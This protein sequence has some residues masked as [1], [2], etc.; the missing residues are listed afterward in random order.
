VI[1]NL[2]EAGCFD[3][4]EWSR[5]AML[6]SVEPMYEE[7]VK[8]QKEA[9]K[10]VMNLFALIDGEKESRF[11]TPPVVKEKFSKQMIFKRE[12][13]L[14]G[15]Y[16]NGHPLDDF[17]HQLQRLSCVPF[18]EVDKL[19][20]GSVCRIAFII[21]GIVVKIATKSQ[22]KFAILTI[23]DGNGRFELSIW[24]D[25]FEQKGAL[26]Q[27][28]QLLYA[29]VQKEMQESQIRLQ[30]RW[31][32]D[33]TKADEA[34]ILACDDAYDMAKQQAKVFEM[35]EKN[36]NFRS[37]VTKESDP[38]KKKFQRLNIQFDADLARLSHILILKDLF[39]AHSGDIPVEITFI[40]KKGK[41]GTLHIDQSWGVDYR[42][43]IEKKISV[44]SS[45]KSCKWE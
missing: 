40:G 13:E 24:P 23:G 33:L 26:I 4:T 42:V 19:P 28:N 16:L 32:N 8:E 2:I 25:L 17:H 27:E 36:K 1:E 15:I 31:L 3:F 37:S 38:N 30:C 45:V 10:G 44:I 34:M 9:A 22:R 14:L 29:V 39:R 20:A 11:K 12:Y 7:V 6:L 41:I 35:R 5:E 43:E 18:T 21:E